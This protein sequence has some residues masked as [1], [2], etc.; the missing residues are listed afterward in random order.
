MLRATVA[1]VVS[2]IAAKALDDHILAIV[3][4]GFIPEG[5]PQEGYRN[6]R[7][8]AAYPLARL[9]DLGAKAG[10]RNRA[11]VASFTSLLTDQNPIIRHWAAQALPML[12][13]DAASARAALE[14]VMRSDAVPQN[15]VVAAEAIATIAPSPEAVSVLAG[16]VDA[17]DPWQ[18][19]LQALNSL[20]FLGDRGQCCARP[21]KSSPASAAVTDDDA[22]RNDTSF[23]SDDQAGRAALQSRRV[24]VDAV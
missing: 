14:R 18:V 12:G 16:L 7:D 22:M 2:A 4:N 15:R 5:M 9:M 6:S 23:P 3:D 8:S 10:A 19:S 21:I 20:T 13:S 1:T 11:N 17:A 24:I